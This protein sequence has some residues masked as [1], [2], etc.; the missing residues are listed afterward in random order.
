MSKRS[1][2]RFPRRERDFYPTPA[3]AVVPLLPHLRAARVRQ[4]AEPCRGDGALVRILESAG[5]ECIYQGDIANGQDALTVPRFPAPAIT[6]PPYERAV[7]H[8]LIEHFLVAAEF[9]WLLLES[10]WMMTRQARPYMP[11]CSDVVVVGRLKWIPDSPAASLD[12]FAR[13]R[14]D[15]T[16]GAGPILHTTATPTR[17][18]A[19]AQCGRAFSPTRSDARFCNHACR[20]RAYE[21]RL[22]VR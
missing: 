7:L 12:N 22:S 1:P 18:V 4:F 19:C 15:R 5:L 13:F 11:H 16:H 6:N 14:F 21:R 17:A 2:D 20:Q 3:K 10:D 8:R 9:F